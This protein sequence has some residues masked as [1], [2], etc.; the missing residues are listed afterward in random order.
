MRRSNGSDKEKATSA[1]NPATVKTGFNLHG[2][3]NRSPAASDKTDARITTTD[4][5]QYA[6][7]S[8]RFDQVLDDEDY[9]VADE[10]DSEDY[11]MMLANDEEVKCAPIQCSEEDDG[12]DFSRMAKKQSNH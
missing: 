10:F 4:M 8:K 9:F 7:R 3:P 11:N 2:A 5:T 6:R 1:K 12:P